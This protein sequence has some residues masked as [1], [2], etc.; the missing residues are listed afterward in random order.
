MSENERRGSS[1]VN[2]GIQADTVT[3]D[4]IAVGRGA[5]ASKTVYSS[6]GQAELLRAIEQLSGALES[7]GLQPHAQAALNEDV[8]E[9]RSVASA[10]EPRADRAAHALEGLSGKLKMAGVVLSHAAALAEP[11]RKIAGL[12]HIPLHLIGL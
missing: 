3:G 11:V 7:L 9:L 1:Q 12:L 5:V 10:K 8:R 4:V 2:E 6:G